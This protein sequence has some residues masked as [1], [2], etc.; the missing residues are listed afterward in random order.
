[1]KQSRIKKLAKQEW[2]SITF[3]KKRS[4]HTWWFKSWKKNYYKNNE[5]GA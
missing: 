2:I 4:S 1:M 5:E 3:D